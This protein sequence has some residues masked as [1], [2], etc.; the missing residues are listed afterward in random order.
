MGIGQEVA[1]EMG[2]RGTNLILVARREENLQGLCQEIK[3]W[4]TECQYFVC[5]L[6]NPDQ[7]ETLA[8]KVLLLPRLDGIV[9]N[10][11]IGLYSKL[12]TLKEED[13]RKLFE[14]NFF[15][16]IKLTQLLIPLLKKSK[17]PRIQMVSSVVAW[18]AIPHM[19]V[20]C[21]SKAAL[22]AFTESLRLELQRYRIK[23]LNV[24]P[25]RTKTEFSQAAKSAGWSPNS[26]EARG[27]SAQKV[28]QKMTRAYI[29]EK[30]DEYIAF[31]NRCLIWGNFLFPKLIDW[32]MQRYFKNK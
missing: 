5:D 25:G 11:G 27:M 21:A 16:I 18:R 30:R 12:E 32:L 20:Y 19:S 28:A 22:N 1:K 26:P 6:S 24:Y 31:S 4:N 29:K 9:H 13:A 8:K 14:V 23:V 7:V 2:R 10:A 15:S 3:Q 17:R